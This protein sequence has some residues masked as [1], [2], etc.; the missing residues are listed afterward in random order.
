VPD[1]HEQLVA[2]EG[3]AIFGWAV[4]G[5]VEVLANGLNDPET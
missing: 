5:A 1:L 4:R 3:P 2:D